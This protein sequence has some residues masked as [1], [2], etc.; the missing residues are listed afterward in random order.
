MTVPEDLALS[1]EDCDFLNDIREE[2][3]LEQR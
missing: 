1:C 3:L 2:S